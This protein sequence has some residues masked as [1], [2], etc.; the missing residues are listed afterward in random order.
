MTGVVT[1]IAVVLALVTVAL[2][3]VRA[4]RN[5][6]PARLEYLAA[7]V[8]EVAVLGYAAVRVVDL[9]GGHRS[10]NLLVVLAYIA[11]IV[12][13]L[14]VTAAL[15]WAEPTRWG[16]VVLA[17]GALVVCVLFARINQLWSPGG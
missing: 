12:L 16:S 13:T 10:S 15:S 6:R 1:A 11:C 9:I 4:L 14:P 8:T 3:A 2:C 7:G 17:A 5:Q